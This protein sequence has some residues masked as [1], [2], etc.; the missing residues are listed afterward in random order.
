MAS[1]PSADFP[2]GT[3]Q[4]TSVWSFDGKLWSPADKVKVT[5][6]CATVLHFKNGSREFIVQPKDP[7]NPVF[8]AL[9]T[10]FPTAAIVDGLGADDLAAL[11]SKYLSELKF[12]GS[13]IRI[14][15]VPLGQPVDITPPLPDEV[16][17]LI[18]GKT[19]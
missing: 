13:Q 19:E 11:S 12:E 9:R 10:Q 8:Q 3:C 17:R 16:R 7:N 2:R 5:G 15:L 18:F 1:V 14:P 4:G 6:N